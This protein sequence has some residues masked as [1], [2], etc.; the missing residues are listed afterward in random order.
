MEIERK[1]MVQGWHQGLPLLETY[2]MDQGYI[3][4]RP[5][6]GDRREA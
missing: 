3:R 2:S 5:T 1:W 6:V 4:V